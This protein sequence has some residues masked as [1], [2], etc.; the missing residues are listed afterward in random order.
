MARTLRAAVAAKGPKITISESLELIAK[1]FGV[2]DWNTLSATIRAQAPASSP[3]PPPTI[4]SVARPGFR[5][6]WG[7]AAP[8]N[9]PTSE[10]KHEHATLEHLLLALIED[11]DAS[12]VMKA[13]SV[14]LGALNE[15]LT[16]QSTTTLKNWSSP[17][18]PGPN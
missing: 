14:D 3:P 4:E 8:A 13:C 9:V 6:A 10:R 7:D 16:S 5:R 2:A 12:A 18:A 17:S 11:V 1:A 15:R